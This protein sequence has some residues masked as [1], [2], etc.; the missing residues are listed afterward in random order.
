MIA[1]DRPAELIRRA[2]AGEV[3]FP[4]PR[5]IGLDGATPV[6][7]DSDLLLKRLLS[8]RAAQVLEAWLDRTLAIYAD[9][10]G[11]FVKANRDRFANPVGAILREG[12][13]SLW[14]ALLEGADAERCRAALAPIIR[15][16]AVQ[17]APPSQAL[18]FVPVLKDVVADILRDRVREER[19]REAFRAFEARIDR[20]TLLA[21]D[22][23]AECREK[24]FALRVNELKRNTARLPG[25]PGRKRAASGEPSPQRRAACETQEG[26]CL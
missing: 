8:E 22:L 2:D 15:V 21:F 16:K 13:E 5:A 12:L 25:R 1:L 19:A 26:N 14:E 7:T 24:I 17:E 11:R 18:A 20:L 4:H 6:R 10:Y 9:Q 23:Y 3:C